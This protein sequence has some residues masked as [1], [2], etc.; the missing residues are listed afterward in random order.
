MKA[1]RRRVREITAGQGALLENPF[2]ADISKL[3]SV[4]LGT[5]VKLKP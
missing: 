2:L 5:K 4:D 3:S 1:I